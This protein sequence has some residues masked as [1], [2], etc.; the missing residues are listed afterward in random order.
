MRILLYSRHTAKAASSRYRTI[1]YIPSLEAVGHTVLHHPFFDSTHG[2]IPSS[3]F[4]RLFTIF[5]AYVRRFLSAVRE[6]RSAHVVIV[7]KELFPG[8]PAWTE[9]LILAR[10]P[11][12]V[13]DFDDATW[14]AYRRS[15]VWALSMAANKFQATLR[16]RTV[17]V[18][19]GELYTQV[20]RWHVGHCEIIPT[21][22]PQ[23]RYRCQGLEAIKDTDVVW[24][25]SISTGRYLLPLIP[26]FE[27][28]SKEIGIRIRVVGLPR[29]LEDKMPT[30]VTCFP[31]SSSTELDLLSTG[32]I[33]IMP[34][35]D[36]PFERAKC[37]FKLIQYMGLGLPV[38]A[39]PIGENV[40]I[41]QN[42][43]HGFHAS[44]Q[45][46]WEHALKALLA[47]S[48]LRHEMG[49][50]GHQQFCENYSLESATERFRTV[51]EKTSTAL[52]H[53]R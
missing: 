45:D 2:G 6:V 21:V 3:S 19:S 11:G 31:W 28:L 24:I 8:L 29:E 52:V 25:G 47:D 22:V 17:I 1:Q 34:L 20:S 7:E 43:V 16:G 40:R 10:T 5:M 30:C 4:R 44:T 53:Q 37:G 38:V 39:S 26:V 51:L 36:E 49:E 9:R 32:K 41:V 18:G 12:V 23:A 46:Q 33:G 14:H 13:Y 42:G 35:P 27:N 48:D 15:G 50:R